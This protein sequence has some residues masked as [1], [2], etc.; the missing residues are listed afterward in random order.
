MSTAVLG[1][2][3]HPT[4]LLRGCWQSIFY[5]QFEILWNLLP[6]L[7]QRSPDLV[8]FQA[9]CKRH[10]FVKYLEK[11][12]ICLCSSALWRGSMKCWGADVWLFCLCLDTWADNL[13]IWKLNRKYIQTWLRQVGNRE[14]YL[15]VGGR[16]NSLYFG[17][18][19]LFIKGLSQFL[20]VLIGSV[21]SL[22]FSSPPSSL[23]H[24]MI[25]VE[26]FCDHSMSW[27]LVLDVDRW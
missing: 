13:I 21:F 12:R 17:K 5:E 20:T 11:A 8:T 26:I 2:G 18:K 19:E 25:N 9:C 22:C 7:V 1:G 10:A 16:N 3:I 4:P 27:C 23:S 24:W 15:Q 14:F 6:T